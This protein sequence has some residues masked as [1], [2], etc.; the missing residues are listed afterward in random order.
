MGV[1]GINDELIPYHKWQG[2]KIGRLGHYFYVNKEYKYPKMISQKYFK[3]KKKNLKKL[4]F[5]N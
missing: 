3:L 4:N 5:K 2:F 1:V